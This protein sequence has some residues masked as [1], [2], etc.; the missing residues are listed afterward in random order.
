M[1][2]ARHCHGVCLL[3]GLCERQQSGL[4]IVMK[5]YEQSLESAIAAAGATGLDEARVRRYAESLSRTLQE[6]HESGLVLRDIKP[7]NIL[8]DAYDQP[9]FADFGIAVFLQTTVHRG[10]SIAGTWNYMAPEAFEP[11]AFAEGI[12]RHTDVWA[13]ACVIGE[14]RT[15][16]RPWADMQMQQIMMAVCVQQRTPQ[17]PQDAPAAALLRRCFERSPTQR[18]TAANLADAF[19]SDVREGVESPSLTLAL[20]LADQEAITEE[21]TR[22]NS[23]LTQDNAR[24]Q[25]EVEA[26][27]DVRRQGRELQGNVQQLT[28]DNAR[29]TQDNARLQREVEALEDV[30]RQER[31]LQG[32]V[33]Q[34][35]QENAR[36]TQ[37]TQ[38]LQQQE[39]Q[40]IAQPN[41]DGGQ[42]WNLSLKTGVSIVLVICVEGLGSYCTVGTRK[43]TS[44]GAVIATAACSV[45]L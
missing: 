27:E 25:R 1:H 24:L 9:V 33:Q 21:V 20:R 30:S 6:L 36:L 41:G 39:R 19:A 35:T 11:Q 28:Q 8:L 34:L 7:P 37:L 44:L 3:Y 22:V 43:G 23:R 40:R 10:T 16:Q 17:V 45:A 4:C 2:A 15:G 18:P 38:Q 29:L 12:G 31:A 42:S 5:R 14:M 13:L 32:N 26:L